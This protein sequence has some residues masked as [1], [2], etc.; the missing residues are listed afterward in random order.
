MKH[1]EEVAE[2]YMKGKERNG[3]PKNREDITR[4]IRDGRRITYIIRIF[5]EG[6]KSE[7]VNTKDT[8]SFVGKNESDKMG[9]IDEETSGRKKY[10]T[11]R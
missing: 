9:V 4:N 7:D 3:R 2:W 5:Q 6:R 8:G 11:D 10:S 1:Q